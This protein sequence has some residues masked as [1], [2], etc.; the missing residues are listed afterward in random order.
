MLKSF[1]R[2]WQNNI[3]CVHVITHY[4]QHQWSCQTQDNLVELHLT[5]L[6]CDD[7]ILANARAMV[8]YTLFI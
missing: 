6:T 1:E 2:L 5:V 4:V 7:H 3:H 8:K